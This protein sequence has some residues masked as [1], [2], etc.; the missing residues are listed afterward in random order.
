MPTTFE[1]TPAH[2]A[3]FQAVEKADSNLTISAVA[4]S[5]KSTT[6]I[7][8]LDHIPSTQSVLFVVFNKKNAEELKERIGNTKPNVAVMTLNALGH[9][10]YCG[11][12][13]P[14]PVK[15]D[16]DKLRAITK[17]IITNSNEHFLMGATV[18]KLCRLAKA[19]GVVP[20]NVP[21]TMPGLMPDTFE[22]WMQII[23]MYDV[24]LPENASD[25]V[26]IDFARRVLRESVATLDVIDFDDQL[27]M[28]F[29]YNTPF[30][31]FDWVFCD[32]SQDN[33]LLQQELVGRSV[34]STGHVVNVGDENQAIYFW[35]GALSDSMNMFSKRFNTKYLP[36]HVSYRCPQ[37][38]V[39]I[40]QRYVPHI[41]AH[42]SATLG[43]VDETRKPFV[44]VTFVPGDLIV[45]RFNAPLVQVAYSLLRKRIPCVVMGRDIGQ[46]LIALIKKLRAHDVPTLIARLQ[47]WEEK[48]VSRLT[49][50]EQDERAAA[51]RDKADTLRVFLESADS[52]P[53]LQRA[54]ERTFD[55]TSSDKVV[56][57]SSVHRAKGR[58]AVR[59]FI[60]NF[61]D[62]PCKWARTPE[63]QRQEL[64]IIYVALTRSK[65]YLGFVVVP[66]PTK[67]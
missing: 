50:L 33:S 48:E 38:V 37:N 39:K 7:K 67:R 45:C 14:R 20:A 56:T 43:T 60:V 53:E 17:A 9:R 47:D 6:L 52:I 24:D 34:K 13:N 26:I 27:L 12:R 30:R 61:D 21:G 36:L 57:L 2:T 19:M 8:L 1:E 40:A 10:A 65:D 11:W 18:T 54:I 35:R 46:G 44:D 23:D 25:V 62:M 59:V 32:E 51:A 3:I 4:G 63:A 66:R 29:A 28:S 41:Q 55:D 58:E 49:S 5:G 31:K 22:T 42:S 15:V 16:A 64:N